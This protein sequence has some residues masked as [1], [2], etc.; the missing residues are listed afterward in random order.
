MSRW[1]Y[2]FFAVQV[3]VF[4]FSIYWSGHHLR[5]KK[6]VLR[7]LSWF[8][9]GEEQIYELG[10]LTKYIVK[11]FLD[12]TG[13]KK[14]AL[15]LYSRQRNEIRLSAFHGV[16]NLESFPPLVTGN[17]VNWTLN[18]SSPVIPLKECTT[19][20]FQESFPS[21]KERLEKE[22]LSY[23]I[24][25][26]ERNYL[27]GLLAVGDVSRRPAADVLEPLSNVAGRAI[28]SLYLYESSVTDETTGLYN[29]RFFRQT[30]QAELRRSD[31]Y[32]QP[33]SLLAFDIDDFKKIND[34][35]GHP[36]GDRVLKEL[37]ECILGCLRDGIDI[38]ARTGGEEFHVILP[39]TDPDRAL[40]VGERIV[41][42]VRQNRFTGFPDN[43]RVTIST[44]T[45]TYPAHAREEAE[46]ISLAD[47]ALYL[48]KSKGK[49]RICSAS[50]LGDTE[51]VEHPAGP[52]EK[53][54]I[55]DP[56]TSL[57]NAEYFSLRL[58]E[59]LKRSVRYRFPCSLILLGFEASGGGPAFESIRKFA[60][61]LKE[62]LRTGIDTPAPLDREHVAVIIP[63]TKKENAGIMAQRIT[64]LADG[65]S[66]SAGV[67]SFPEDAL[68]EETLMTKAFWALEEAQKEGGSQCVLWEEKRPR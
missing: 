58:K 7:T 9:E 25:L 57:Y 65:A 47:K 38:A 66:V 39:A 64:A 42:T 36:Q 49:D 52:R 27:L 60:P 67:V 24:P 15:F 11:F 4:L 5:R 1:L 28:E 8:D 46:L 10:E 44:G 32:T 43:R 68:T 61:A 6:A 13:G 63:E 21:L 23:L 34:T 18:L 2:G 54:N 19:L 40:K 17:V 31:R 56:A 35:Y 50:E 33:C 62:S 29:K 20:F 30:L 51:M 53:L 26:T 22:G 14:G 48:A 41:A 55:F 37:S 45:A 3:L 59:E 12:V 16:G